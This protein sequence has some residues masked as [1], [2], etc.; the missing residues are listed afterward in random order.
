MATV[1]SQKLPVFPIRLSCLFLLLAI[2]GSAQAEGAKPPYPPG[3]LSL[4]DLLVPSSYPLIYLIQM[5]IF[6]PGIFVLA[7]GGGLA[8]WCT[9][10]SPLETNLVLAAMSLLFI[11]CLIAH[12]DL[13]MWQPYNYLISSFV[14]GIIALLGS[15]ACIA[16]CL[17]QRFVNVTLGTRQLIAM[18]GPQVVLLGWYQWHWG[19]FR[20]LWQVIDP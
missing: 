6:Y 2:V 18:V 8:I 1:Q 15:S 14:V 11:A 17:Y 5:F 12:I 10:R 20:L 7:S 13:M 4:I 19:F 16:W 9:R 3:K